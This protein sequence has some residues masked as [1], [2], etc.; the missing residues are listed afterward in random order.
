MI[1]KFKES[2]PC[3]ISS[4]CFG[5]L[6]GTLLIPVFFYTY[7][8]I[9]GKNIFILDISTFILSV[10]IAFLISYKFSQSCILKPYTFLLCILVGIV[11]ICFTVFTIYPPDIMI[12]KEPAM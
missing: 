11:F 2:H 6:I 3:I 10:I 7:T 9:L 8:Y 4:L 1:F 5:I 12:F